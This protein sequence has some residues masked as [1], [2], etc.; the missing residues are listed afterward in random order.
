MD[1]GLCKM[2]EVSFW[3]GELANWLI[4]AVRHTPNPKAH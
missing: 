1:D 2:D 3:L 4:D